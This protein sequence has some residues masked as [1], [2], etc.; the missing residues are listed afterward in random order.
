MRYQE[1]FNIV[2][3]MNVDDFGFTREV[4]GFKIQIYSHKKQFNIIRDDDPRFIITNYD[5]NEVK[6]YIA[7]DG[8]VDYN[9]PD[10]IKNID[11]DVSNSIEFAVFILDLLG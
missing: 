4:A 1:L 5:D 7:R 10:K 8:C 2:K 6:I 9:H 11:S 3:T